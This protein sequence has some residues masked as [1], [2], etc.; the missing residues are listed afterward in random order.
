MMMSAGSNLVNDVQS[1]GSGNSDYG[2]T[3]DGHTFT[4]HGYE[5]S[6]ERG[7]CHHSSRTASSINQIIIMQTSY[8][9]ISKHNSQVVIELSPEKDLVGTSE[10][11]L[12]LDIDKKT[13][14]LVG[15]EIVDLRG[16]AGNETLT[17]E[18]FESTVEEII[19]KITYEPEY[20]IGYVGFKTRKDTSIETRQTSGNIFWNPQGNVVRLEFPPK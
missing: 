8:P 2:T 11:D 9:R 10:V 4:K 17:L 3:P 15:V 19:W 1:S 16:Q 13:K 7:S 14:E 5:R 6:Q 18:K 12:I 20:D